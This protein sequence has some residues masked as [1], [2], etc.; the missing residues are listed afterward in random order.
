MLSDRCQKVE[1]VA[2]TADECLDDVH[3]AYDFVHPFS[4]LSQACLQFS[5]EW[6]HSQSS[7][8]EGSWASSASSAI[9]NR[10]Q[11]AR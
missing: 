2:V 6:G 5:C 10:L 11:S 3:S 7:R 8:V 4:V 9:P 1:R